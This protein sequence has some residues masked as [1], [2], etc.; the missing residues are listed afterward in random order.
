MGYSQYIIGVSSNKYL[1]DL[2][3]F[4]AANGWTVDLDGVY[5]TSYRRL[6]FHKGNAHYDL[7]SS[8]SGMVYNNGCTGFASGSAPNAQPG[9]MS[10]GDSSYTIAYAGG[11][12][13]FISTA[14]AIYVG[15]LSNSLTFTWCSFFTIQDKFGS[16]TDGFGLY[17]PNVP[18]FQTASPGSWGSRLY[19]NGAWGGPNLAGDIYGSNTTSELTAKHPNKYN[20]GIIPYPVL[21]CVAPAIDLNKRVPLGYAPGLYR[22]NAGDIYSLGEQLTIGADTYMFFPRSGTT[23]GHAANSD[24]L[25]KLGA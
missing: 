1:T 10:N 22:A 6:H 3:A 11:G 5:N 18:L 9:A 13:W 17:M 24:Y 8:S 4:V 15:I 12:Y 7:Y 23:I 2:S 16:Y 25:F 21:I 20:A 14:G 19:Y